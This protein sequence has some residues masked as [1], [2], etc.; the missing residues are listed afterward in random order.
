MANLE[1]EDTVDSLQAKETEHTVPAGI[2]ALFGGLIVWGIYYFVA[3][4]GWDQAE[5]VKSGGAALGANVTHTIAYT[6][7]PTVVILALAFAMSRRSKG[8]GK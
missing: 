1:L 5:D 4:I 3:Y 7:I 6:A 2:W 8:K